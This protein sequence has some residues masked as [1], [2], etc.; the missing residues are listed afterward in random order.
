MKKDEWD[1]NVNDRFM[2]KDKSKAT[3]IY[4]PFMKK[5]E[6]DENVS[7]RFMKKDKSKAIE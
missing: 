1:E 6:W 3:R 5:D 2:K 4:S 7:D